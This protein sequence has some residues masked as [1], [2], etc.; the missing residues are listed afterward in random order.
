MKYV[1]LC[2]HMWVLQTWPCSLMNNNYACLLW[3]YCIWHSTQQ[4]NS[5]KQRVAVHRK[6]HNLARLLFPPGCQDDDNVEWQIIYHLHESHSETAEE[7]MLCII[8]DC[9]NQGYTCWIWYYTLQFCFPQKTTLKFWNDNATPAVA[10]C[11]SL[12]MEMS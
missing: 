2:L 10:L 3:T 9:S 1:C 7:K 4:L 6:W 8:Q 11:F 5:F 12:H